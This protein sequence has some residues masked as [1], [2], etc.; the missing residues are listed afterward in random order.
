MKKYILGLLLAAACLA[1]C[2]NP[3][4][5]VEQ[6]RVNGFTGIETGGASDVTLF[7]D[8]DNGSRKNI[9]LNGGSLV[10]NDGRKTLARINAEDVTI[11][12]HTSEVVSIP[13]NV[14][15]NQLQL[16]ASFRKLTQQ[17]E[18]LTVTGE[19]TVKSGMLRKKF[20]FA[21]KPLTEFL[22]EIGLD[23]RSVQK[24]LEIK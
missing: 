2:A 1:S 16:L 9:C 3:N 14:S 12:R 11:R 18:A 21:D 7:F 17:P 22:K 4:K 20:N 8:I 23:E 24:M 5:I 19:V 15:L 6:V 10:I 13:L